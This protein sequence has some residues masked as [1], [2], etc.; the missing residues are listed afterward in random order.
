MCPSV[1]RQPATIQHPGRPPPPLG[2]P[3]DRISRPHSAG[4]E[5]WTSNLLSIRGPH[6]PTHGGWLLHTG[7]AVVRRQAQLPATSGLTPTRW[8]KIV[9]GSGS[10]RRWLRTAGTAV[11]CLRA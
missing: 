4:K 10:S 7:P 8:P 2:R 3:C 5:S 6:D 11:R 1:G 9:L